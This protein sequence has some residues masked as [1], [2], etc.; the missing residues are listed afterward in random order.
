M[1]ELE[2][3]VMSLETAKLPIV[4]EF[5]KLNEV[6]FAYLIK[7]KSTYKLCNCREAFS[8]RESN[9]QLKIYQTLTISEMIDLLPKR[10]YEKEGLRHITPHL[11]TYYDCADN[12]VCGYKSIGGDTFIMNFSSKIPKETLEKLLVWC[13][14]EGYLKGEK[15]AN[16]N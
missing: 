14:E 6:K 12:F 4:Q 7:N 15:N 2:T 10:I 9:N 5:L 13:L 1:T 11:H 8:L 16:D 3:E